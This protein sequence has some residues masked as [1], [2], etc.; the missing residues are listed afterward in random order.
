MSPERHR[1]AVW[2]ALLAALLTGG[3]ASVKPYE[4]GRLAHPSMSAAR[5]GGAGEAHLHAV[6]E[7]ATGGALGAESG[8]GCN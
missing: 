4:R 5:S 8:C 7:G 1:R 2:A 6:H 3:C